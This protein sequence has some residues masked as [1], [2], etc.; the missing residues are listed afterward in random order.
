[1]IKQKDFD[2]K[3][4]KIINFRRHAKWLI[5]DLYPSGH[6]LSHLG[7]SGTWI[8]SKRPLQ[9]K[10]AHII[11]TD[12]TKNTD[13]ESFNTL[14]YVDPRRFGHFYVLNEENFKA[15]MNLLPVDISSS[16]FDESMIALQFF[17]APQK[18]LKPYLLD[19]AAFPGVGNYMASEICA[20]SGILPSRLCGDIT[21]IE[22]TK[23]K[24]AM[25]TVIN[26]AVDTKGTTFSGGY[27]DADGNKG[28][29]VKHLVVFY[30]AHCQMCLEKGIVTEV[31]KTV[32]NT[33][34]TYHCPVCQK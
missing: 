24:Q 18:M 6:I 3:G 10:H 5:F 20:R 25:N 15:R 29:G 11:L 4:R 33:R 23:I 7:M 28:E 8:R 16:D 31:I 13:D 1:M 9:E 30:Q 14:T 17:K 19:Q 2:L 26:G 21:D 12:N 22:I 34:G 32:M 27:R